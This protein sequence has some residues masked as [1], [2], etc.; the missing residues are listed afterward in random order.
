MVNRNLILEL[1]IL[2][3]I[4]QASSILGQSFSEVTTNL[5]NLFFSSVDWV[6]YDNDG[7]LDLSLTGVPPGLNVE[8]FF[9]YANDQGAFDRLVFNMELRRDEEVIWGDYD[10]DGDPDI[11][12]GEVGFR[13]YLNEGKG[14]FR[15]KILP[16]EVNLILYPHWLDFDNDGDSEVFY[17]GQGTGADRPT[18]LRNEKNDVFVL[19]SQFSERGAYAWGDY[20]NDSYLDVM[21]GTGNNKA[22]LYTNSGPGNFSKS[23]KNIR[24]IIVGALLWSDYNNDGYQDLVVNGSGISAQGFDTTFTIIYKNEQGTGTF[25]NIHAV[26]DGAENRQTYWGDY[27]NDGDADFLLT[28]SNQQKIVVAK[29]YRNEGNDIFVDSGIRFTPN[30]LGDAA[31]G[32]FDQDGDLDL[33]LTGS[34]NLG[35]T[36]SSK[37]FRNETAVKNN[38]PQAPAQLQAFASGDSVKLSWTPVGND[39]TPLSGLTFN[40]RVGTQPGACDIVSPLARASDGKRWVA[41]PGN[42]LHNTSFTLHGLLNGTYYWSVQAIDHSFSSSAFAP[43]A[44]FTILNSSRQTFT[45]INAGVIGTI[46]GQVKWGDYDGD[47]DLDV[48]ITGYNFFL[49]PPSNFAKIYRNDNGRFVDIHAS[50]PDVAG[51]FLAWADYDNDGDLD[52]LL[53][54]SDSSSVMTALYRNEGGDRFSLAPANFFGLQE[55]AAA[56]GD[57]DNDG[58]LDLLISGRPSPF[59]LEETKLYRNDSNNQFTEVST[60]LPKVYNSSLAWGDIDNDGDLDL[61]LSG[62]TRGGSYTTRI[63]R[64]QG[65]DSFVDL[66]MDFTEIK[67]FQQAGPV[68]WGDV[69]NDGD[70]DLLAER[71]I[72]TNT[73]GQ[74]SQRER[75]NIGEFGVGTST[76]GDMDNDGDLDILLT[77]FIT[78]RAVPA[79]TLVKNNNRQS[80]LN[81]AI[82][83]I[84]PRFANSDLGDYDNDGDLD[85]IVLGSGIGYLNAEIYRNDGLH[86][87]NRPAKPISPVTTIQNGEVTLA[88]QRASDS[89]TPA[90]GLTYNLRIGTTAENVNAKSPMADPKTGVRHLA[91]LGN[92]QQNN[93]WPFKTLTSGTYDWSVQALDHGFAGSEFSQSLQFTIQA[94]AKLSADA[95]NFGR[96]N[97]GESKQLFLTVHNEGNI[98]LVI[99]EALSSNIS[100]KITPTS[101]VINPG[102]STQLTVTF[103]P[104]RPNQQVATLSLPHNGLDSPSRVHLLG[105]AVG[106]FLTATKSSLDF[107]EVRVNESKSIDFSIRNE[108]NVDLNIVSVSSSNSQFRAGTAPSRLA[109]NDSARMTVTFGPMTTGYVL[110]TLRIVHSGFPGR[111]LIP[112]SAI[113][114]APVKVDGKQTQEP[115][116]FALLQCYPNPFNASTT[117]QFFLARAAEVT[118]RIFDTSGKEV[119]TLVKE[120]LAAGRHTATW[121]ASGFTNGVYFYRLQAGE[122]FSQ[123]KKFVL[124]K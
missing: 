33:A 7:D 4:S 81:S 16:V 61:A 93:V 31:W 13:V 52:L 51:G 26:I 19:F 56:W 48:A 35:I 88:W 24:S 44:S 105:F 117:I 99:R 124:L 91:A 54:G 82:N 59:A 122:A 106:A 28:G 41:Q 112:M 71:T 114:T 72:F 84:P 80:F 11:L 100:F 86:P 29:I 20:N 104:T 90:L 121:E 37:I 107:G 10:N 38:I 69:D 119:A 12:T 21:I 40:L 49:E 83:I 25:T 1:I 2:V 50:L 85:I 108:G 77:G 123:T 111:T 68:A 47:A 89:E 17:T 97:L 18:L 39:E 45:N 6:D 58:D 34:E 75:L 64:N 87:N 53:A 78:G 66:G 62:Q 94:K 74:F 42:A 102:D 120:Y 57:Y 79:I 103:E 60:T 30:S 113:A 109:P 67:P 14:V 95:L 96:V 36:A 118:L 23:V 70:L 3:F 101:A 92:V 8:Q 76:M 63:F 55:G 15:E 110:D 9:L 115:E 32:D 65:A 5:P 27:D 43:E 98:K 73:N 46:Y 116:V 22:V